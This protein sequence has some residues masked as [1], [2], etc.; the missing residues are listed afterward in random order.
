MHLCGC[1]LCSVWRFLVLGRPGAEAW[2]VAVVVVAALGG[3]P[4]MV[5]VGTSHRLAGE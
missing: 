2:V 4:V 5:V 1:H 3:H